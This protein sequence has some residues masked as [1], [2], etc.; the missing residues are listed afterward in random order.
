MGGIK[1]TC[2]KHGKESLRV[3]G[4][5]L[6]VDLTSGSIHYEKTGKYVPRFIG[7]LGIGLKIMWDE[8]GPKVKPYDPEN[9]LMFAAGPLTGT[10]APS[11][12][13]TTVISK[14]PVTYPV[15]HITHGS[16]G[17]HFGAELKMAGYDLIVIRGKARDPVYLSVKDEKVYIRKALNIWG[18]D[19]FQ[20]QKLIIERE[21]DLQAKCAVIGQVGERCSFI[22]SIISET[23]HANGQYGFGG[24]MGSKNLKGIVVRGTGSVRISVP[25]DKIQDVYQNQWKPLLNHGGSV[26]PGKGTWKAGSSDICWEGNPGR[27]VIGE[28]KAQEMN[29]TGLRCNASFEMPTSRYH[30]KNDGCFGCV[31]NCFSY[32]RMEGLPYNI[33]PGGQMM[34]Q[35]FGSYFAQHSWDFKKLRVSGQAVFAGKQLADM[36]SVN[37]VEMRNIRNL[38]VY[39]KNGH[40]KLT[41]L[42]RKELDSLP[43]ET[44]KTEENGLPFI[45]DLTNKLARADY[46]EENLWGLLSRGVVRAACSLGVYED[47]YNGIDPK[48]GLVFTNNGIAA[49]FAPR[50]SPVIALLWMMENRDPNRHDLSNISDC[51]RALNRRGEITEKLF[52]YKGITG[53]GETGNHLNP[54]TIFF[55]KWILTRGILKNS[56][57]LCDWVFPN[58]LSPF[59]ERDYC[60]D[61]SLESKIYSAVT[62]HQVEMEELDRLAEGIW[63]LQRALTIRDWQTRD[64]RGAKGYRAGGMGDPGGD[65]RGHDNL[66]ALYFKHP[67]R[68]YW[69]GRKY[70][71]PPLDRQK[72]EEAKTMLYR[73]M[74][75]DHNGAP[76]RK[77][78]ESFNLKEVADELELS[79]LSGD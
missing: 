74:G 72:Y 70:R 66:A 69:A 55:T 15:N 41:S 78:L 44:E 6:R 34:C 25:Y 57:T 65:F 40:G 13:R 46:R 64:M 67:A 56:L 37:S 49:H 51:E 42:Q 10:W 19:S 73:Q 58:Y 53:P 54:G 16:F 12:G 17:G 59:K 43:W 38:L 23:G 3:G 61:L 31:F 50:V 30:V 27:P 39:L 52:K 14:S 32:V 7:G 20:A 79:G 1:E 8:A 63:H 77:T 33:P 76:T 29:R 5:I 9:F 47:I 71:F 75:W 28:V 21:G 22:A 45:W 2:K 11:A 60:G 4:K 18:T 36:Y 48:Y 62:G 24:V 26:V 35:Q 68:F